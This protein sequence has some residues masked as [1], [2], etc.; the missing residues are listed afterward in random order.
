[1]DYFTLAKDILIPILLGY[2][3][4]NEKDKTNMKQKI[5]V[6]SPKTDVEN[7]ID[8]KMQRHQVEIA[9]IKEDLKRIETKLDRLID[10][11]ASY[12]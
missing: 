5:E 7:L 10:R 8:L 12:D 6:T 2:V 4:Y 3:A 11:L 9:S 1:M